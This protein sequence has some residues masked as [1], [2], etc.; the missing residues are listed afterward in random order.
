MTASLA[1]K[2]LQNSLRM[3][4]LVYYTFPFLSLSNENGFLRTLHC[5]TTEKKHRRSPLTT[6]TAF[7]TSKHLQNSLGGDQFCVSRENSYPVLSLP[8]EN[9]LVRTLHC[10]TR[11]NKQILR[12]ITT[13]SASLTSK[14]LQN[15]LR[16]EPTLRL[17][18]ILLSAP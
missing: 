1:S 14:R 4:Q 10:T 17:E 8:G 2:H 16:R 11:D 7:L 13:V 3:E 15:S 18:R 12:T 5:T 9:S 6:K